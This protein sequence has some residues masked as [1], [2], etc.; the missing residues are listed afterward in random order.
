MRKHR[1]DGNGRINFLKIIVSIVLIVGIIAATIAIT[2]TVCNNNRDV[3]A[4]TFDTVDYGG[5]QLVPQLGDDG[6]FTFT[7]DKDF[8]IMQLTDIHI[9]GGFMSK[10]KDEMALNA[11]AAMITAEK[12]DLVIVTGDL[13]YPVPFQAGTFNNL[14]SSK[15][16]ALLMEKLG[17]YWTIGFGNHDTEAYSYYPREKLSE[18]YKN[19]EAYPH[20]IFL[21]NPQNVEIDGYGNQLIKV[22]NSAGKVTQALFVFDS[23][24][25]TDGDYFGIFW[26]Y[27]YI[28]QS[29]IDWYAD[30]IKKINT[31]NATES[32][33]KS[34]AFFHIP[35]TQYN[36]A[37]F[38]YKNNG[39]K[40]TADTKY[41]YGTAGENPEGK[42]VYSTIK[43]EKDLLFDKMLELGSTKAIFCGHDHLNN[44]NL[45]YKG[46][47]LVYGYSVDYLA[48]SKISEFGNQRGCTVIR[49]SS[50]GS[51]SISP[52]SYYQDKYVPK[53]DKESVSK[54]D[55]YDG[56]HH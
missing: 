47:Q 44:F 40:D 9:G 16:F 52:E 24:S 27:D 11:V 19:K 54:D 14:A 20:C 17:V 41:I 48:Y 10:D 46:I 23:H 36:T 51:I 42:V 56:I 13:A 4:Q 53:Y 12:P 26:K 30:A 49:C 34:M 6:Y 43:P 28:K 33:V 32:T 25:Y 3:F 50:D 37:W 7:T 38:D 55:Y 2:N 5:Q 22:K 29:Q 8:K 35:L 18:F 15:S 31:D 39:Y 21:E 45:E 1:I